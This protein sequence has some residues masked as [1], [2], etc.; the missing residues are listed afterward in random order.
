MIFRPRA[1]GHSFDYPPAYW[2][3]M[4]YFNLYRLIIACILFGIYYLLQERE[5]WNSYDAMLYFWLSGGY[6]SFGCAM[7][8]L[9]VA[10]WPRFIRQL[11]LQVMGDI[12]FIV[13]LMYA[14]GGAKSGLGLLL[15]VAIAGAGLISQGRLALFYAALATI[16]LLLGQT[17]QMLAGLATYDD[18]SQIVMLGLSCFATA[19]LAHTFARRTRQSEELASQRGID[20][21]NLAQVNQLIIRDMQYGIM[22][23]DADLRLR[24]HNARAEKLL[25]AT[26]DGWKSTSLERVAPD[27]AR[28]YQ[29][30]AQ[31]IRKSTPGDLRIAVD[32]RELLLRFLPI[33]ANRKSG[34]VI[35]IE[36]WG[37]VQTQAM[38][39]KL[40]ALGRLTANIAHEIRNPLSAISHA[41]QLMQ[42]E[43][44]PDPGMRRLLQII[45][46]NVERLD[47]LVQDVMQLSRRDRM[48]QEI[49]LLADFLREFRD[50]FCESEHVPYAGVA[51]VIA[52]EQAQV[53]FDRNQLHQVLWNLCCNGWRHGRKQ[54]GSLTLRLGRAQRQGELMLE[55]RDDGPGI[56]AEIHARLFEPFFTT[57]ESGTG[58]GLYLAREVCEAND[59]GIA[60]MESSE[61]ACFR[62]FMREHHD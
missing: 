15:V 22:V 28:L 32:G 3:T 17:W 1:A 26:D 54:A 39:L 50:Q 48:Q 25:G 24:H 56:P 55:V 42:E 16:A 12:A 51:L 31:G 11:T 27:I 59:A 8:L 9:T 18:Y 46:T 30:W 52:E 7:A 62:I 36:D 20:L 44:P 61:G 23:V 13:M 2:R 21:E 14:S 53:L 41:N 60:C 34:A 33:G 37:R 49:I 6:L 10:R 45:D 29:E 4:H 19:W 5:W 58:L 40:A 47:H 57:E 35:F 38:Q 43:A